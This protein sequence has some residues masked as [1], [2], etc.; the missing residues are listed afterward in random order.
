MES[1]HLL[2]I[3]LTAHPHQLVVQLSCLQHS[4]Q[5]TE[6][7]LPAA[8]PS[9][10]L[11]CQSLEEPA[12][13]FSIHLLHLTIISRRKTPDEIQLPQTQHRFLRLVWAGHCSSC[14]GKAQ[15]GCVLLVCPCTP[16]ARRSW[17]TQPNPHLGKSNTSGRWIFTLLGTL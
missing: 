9:S 15:A 4:S 16:T 8:S 13:A 11:C 3:S 6:I 7:K 12:A 2:L 17:C 10:C 14:A 1:G 5:N